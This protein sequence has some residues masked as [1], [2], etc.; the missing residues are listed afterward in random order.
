MLYNLFFHFCI[1]VCA[2][3]FAV[4]SGFAAAPS[5]MMLDRCGHGCDPNSGSE[6]P[7]ALD[8]DAAEVLLYA[9]KT[10]E[11]GEQLLLDYGEEYRGH[12]WSHAQPQQ[13]R[14]G[15]RCKHDRRR[16]RCKICR[17]KA[18]PKATNKK[19]TKQKAT[20][21]KTPRKPRRLRKPRRPRKPRRLRKPSNR[22]RKR[23]KPAARFCF[24][25]LLSGFKV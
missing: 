25:R 23:S 22:G 2:H 4:W 15:W 11:R 19:N 1:L 24:Q 10:I 5:V 18:K 14:V 8:D 21:A 9:C 3:Y 13:V 6:C 17:G 20:K 12:D 7:H 16:S